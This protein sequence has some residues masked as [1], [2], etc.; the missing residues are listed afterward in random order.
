V[1]EKMIRKISLALAALAV[2]CGLV[3]AVAAPVSA[4]TAKD[5]VC[6]GINI[7][8]GQC[9]DNGGGLEKVITLV[10]KIISIVAGV[11]AV[12]MIVLAGLRYITSG[13][14]SS[15]VAGAKTAIIY[16]IVGLVIVILSQV[17]VR[18][19]VSSAT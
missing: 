1:E 15:K 2:S 16:A 4:Q 3:F 10:I 13:G 11:A 9:N 19:V 5:A 8:G 18:Y 6:D 17:I 12:I 14:D 7:G